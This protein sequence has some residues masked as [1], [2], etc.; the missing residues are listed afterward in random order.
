MLENLKTTTFN[1]GAPIIEPMDDATAADYKFYCNPINRFV[2]H[3]IRVDPNQH[4]PLFKAPCEGP[5]GPEGQ[6]TLLPRP[7]PRHPPHPAL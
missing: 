5:I 4:W 2:S 7:L 6:R 1:D 3:P